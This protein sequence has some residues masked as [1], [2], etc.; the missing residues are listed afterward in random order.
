ME[1]RVSIIT[2]HF[3]GKPACNEPPVC[4]KNLTASVPGH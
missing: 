4:P 2:P 3:H 1:F